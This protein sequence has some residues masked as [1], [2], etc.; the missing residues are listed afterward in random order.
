MSHSN[1]RLLFNWPKPTVGVAVAF[2]NLVQAVAIARLIFTLGGWMSRKTGTERQKLWRVLWRV[3]SCSAVKP[4]DGNR[5][6]MI[7]RK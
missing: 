2:A 6:K 5:V 3:L 7:R 4:G 1:Q